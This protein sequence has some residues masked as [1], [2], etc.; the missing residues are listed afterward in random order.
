M[1]RT[2]FRRENEGLAIG[3][4]IRVTVLEVGTD[5]VRLAI[6]TANDVPSYREETLWLGG[7]QADGLGADA[8]SDLHCEAL[9]R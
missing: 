6:S 3:D 8:D 7:E 1:L 4:D 5:H 9:A 2:I